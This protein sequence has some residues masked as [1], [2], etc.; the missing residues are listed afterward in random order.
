MKFKDNLIHT[1]HITVDTLVNHESKFKIIFFN[2]I[3]DYQTTKF[4]LEKI[5]KLYKAISHI[6]Q[7]IVKVESEETLF[8]LVC[9]MAVD[10]GGMALATVRKLNP[11]NN[12]LETFTNYGQG[13]DF[14]QHVIM[15]INENIPEGR[16]PA[17]I[18]WRENKMV[19]VKDYQHSELTKPWHKQAKIYGWGCSG[20]F[21]IQ[22]S[23]KPY[24]IIAVYHKDKDAF[25]SE[26]VELLN[27]MTRD[28][29][30]ALDS[31][32]RER[33][34]EKIRD[35]LLA[36]ELHFK[37]YFDRAMVGM[38]AMS[39]VNG[40]LIEVND[41]LC[42]MLGYSAEELTKM[43][44]AEI[45]HPDDI[46]VSISPLNQVIR[47]EI[48]EFEL[49]KRYIKKDGEII[50][51][52]IASRGVYDLKG[53][54][55]YLVTIISDITEIRNNKS[56]IEHLINHDPLTGLANR[57]SLNDYIEASVI[58]SKKYGQNIAICF[59]D[60]DK[61]KHITDIFGR[62]IG[63]LLLV[64]FAKRIKNATRSIDTLARL[65]GDEF[66]LLL[67]VISGR[68]QC[69]K[70]L[71]KIRELI[72]LP[73]HIEGNEIRITVSI[74]VAIYPDNVTNGLGLL[75]RADQAMY[76]AKQQGRNRIHFYDAKNDYAV[77]AR[78]ELLSKIEVA[79]INNELELYYQPVVNMTTGELFGIEALIRWNDPQRGLLLPNEFIP[80]IE[81]TDFEFT[82]TQWVVNQVSRQ[83]DQWHKIGL[84]LSV[85][86]N[87]PARCHHSEE[88]VKTIKQLLYKQKKHHLKP[89]RLEILETATLGDLPSAI[90]RMNQC[91]DE[92]VKF[93]IDDFG[94][95]YSSL[96]YLRQLPA[97]VIK[98]DRSFVSDML[99]NDSDYSLV[100]GIVNLA[101]AFNKQVVAEGVESIE[102]GQ[103]LIEMGCHYGQGYAIA[104]PMKSNQVETWIKEYELP[105]KWKIH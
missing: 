105:Q 89:I 66:I 8:P 101:E 13:S 100:K 60:I 6:N 96:S 91:V 51:A 20:T 97:D 39:A 15:S 77:E 58:R 34:K 92:G 54:I 86:I 63:D 80:F 23:G 55:D 22:K 25:D 90:Q 67:N 11:T 104:K 71:E 61:F 48:T 94:T 46:E 50:Y 103:Q 37:A 76:T 69:T 88:L 52:H 38:A 68:D 40:K 43:S 47:G 42:N 9:E 95:G 79:L 5:T 72:K 81:N 82:L 83:I 44:W 70:I 28:I 33:E 19:I 3:T 62:V 27:E 31:Y 45:T 1:V 53:K 17:G 2:N 41:A 26:I 29:S 84:N 56:Q 12:R 99:S 102:H 18:A 49:N 57:S 24:A 74:G 87:L 73:F 78:S 32:D 65:G 93:S 35:E 14:F 10:Y 75:R 21:P 98:I 4:K 7:A 85:S 16:G 30:F 64:E 36:S 59:I